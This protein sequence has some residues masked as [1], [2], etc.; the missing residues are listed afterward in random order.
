M[1]TAESL[2]RTSISA[3]IRR[4]F[5]DEGADLEAAAQ[6]FREAEAKIKREAFE[7]FFGATFGFNC[8]GYFQAWRGCRVSA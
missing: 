4:I 1:R 2:A 5:A 8:S 3:K 7:R 6:S